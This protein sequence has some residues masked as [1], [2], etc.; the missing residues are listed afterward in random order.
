MAAGRSSER[1]STRAGGGR[2]C[3]CEIRGRGI[4]CFPAISYYFASSRVLLGLFIFE[5]FAVL[6]VLDQFLMKLRDYCKNFLTDNFPLTLLGRRVCKKNNKKIICRTYVL[7]QMINEHSDVK[8][9]SGGS[10][11]FNNNSK[12][13]I[14]LA[15][16]QS[17]CGAVGFGILLFKTRGLCGTNSE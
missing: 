5:L 9:W 7:G 2:F 12:K 14:I 8:E 6:R 16:N 1:H 17:T 11:P 15:Q 13:N 4:V 3:R 10:N